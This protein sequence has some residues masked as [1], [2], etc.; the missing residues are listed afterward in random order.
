MALKFSAFQNE[1]DHLL[2]LYFVKV[3]L[4]LRNSEFCKLLVGIFQER[5]APT[6][7]ATPLLALVDRMQLQHHGRERGVWHKLED[8]NLNH[9]VG[10]SVSLWM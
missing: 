6:E 2:F 3:F 10:N 1:S 7:M 8:G 9:I 4:R 5:S